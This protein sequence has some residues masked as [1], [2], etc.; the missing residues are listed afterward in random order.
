MWSASDSCSAKLTLFAA[1]IPYVIAIDPITSPD[2][3][4][5]PA[6]ANDAVAILF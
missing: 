4:V 2:V 3:L 6:D 5:D 1:G